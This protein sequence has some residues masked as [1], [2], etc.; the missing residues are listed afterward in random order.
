MQSDIA[1]QGT[2]QATLILLAAK[3]KWFPESLQ[4]QFQGIRKQKSMIPR[5]LDQHHERGKNHREQLVA[6]VVEHD[7]IIVLEEDIV[8]QSARIHQRPGYREAPGTK[9]VVCDYPPH[10]MCLL[11]CMLFAANIVQGQETLRNVKFMSSAKQDLLVPPVDFMYGENSRITIPSPPPKAHLF[12]PSLTRPS[13][14][15]FGFR[16]VIL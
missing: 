2:H 10:L 6:A 16:A 15:K 14:S 1:F 3:A 4:L 9:P 8:F 13:R 12:H 7:R 11:I 5:A